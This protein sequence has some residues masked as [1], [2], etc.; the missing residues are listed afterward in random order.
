MAI[1]ARWRMPPESWW[2]YSWARFSG[3]GIWTFRS[4]ST[5]LLPAL[6]RAHPTVKHEHLR[7][8]IAHGVDRVEGGHGLLENHGDAVAADVAHLGRRQGEK[9]LPLEADAAAGDAA[10]RLLD[11]THDGQGGHALAAPAFAHDA[12]GLAAL[13]PEADVV[14]GLGHPIEGDEVGLEV[15]DGE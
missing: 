10:G 8:L 1:M 13:H 12:E 2:G 4:I 9:I 5:A 7:D 11:Q 3:L 6:P 15:L 14:H